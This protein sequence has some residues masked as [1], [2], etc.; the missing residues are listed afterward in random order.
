LPRVAGLSPSALPLAASPAMH[1]I[2]HPFAA[3][4]EAN[5]SAVEPR[6]SDT[7]AERRHACLTLMLPHA[8]GHAYAA[9]VGSSYRLR[10]IPLRFQRNPSR[11]ALAQGQA[12]QASPCFAA[13]WRSTMS[14][15]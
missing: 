12:L 7:A 8:S 1:T 5:V 3:L 13:G 15:P 10:F 2:A 6:R 11:Q 4:A 9:L 14:M